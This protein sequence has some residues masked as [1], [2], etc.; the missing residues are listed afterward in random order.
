MEIKIGDY[1]V[2]SDSMNLWVTKD[3]ISSK[4]THTEKKVA[5]YATNFEQLYT[6]FVDASLRGSDATKTRDFLQK[7]KEEREELLSLWPEILDACEK[8]TQEE[9]K[10][11]RGTSRKKKG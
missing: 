10:K 8:Y 7:V 2:Q 3:F 1:K 5:G 6:Q 4:G 11:K 9:T